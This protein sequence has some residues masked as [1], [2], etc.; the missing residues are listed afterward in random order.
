MA[1]REDP[2]A[3]E[4]GAGATD[5]D[6]SADDDD[7]VGGDADADGADDDCAVDYDDDGLGWE[8]SDIRQGES[9][10]SPATRG[11]VDEQATRK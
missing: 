6:G 2:R 4:S 1:P 11:P 8:W 3:V 9:G 5:G 7:I 10:F